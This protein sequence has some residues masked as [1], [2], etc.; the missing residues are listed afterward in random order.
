MDIESLISLFEA[1]VSKDI[2][3]SRFDHSLRVA[4]LAE[5]FAKVHGYPY[6]R[7][8][9]LAGIVHDITKQ[10]KRDFH[11]EIFRKKGFDFSEIPE[12]AFHAFSGALYLEEKFELKDSE[13]LSA[14]RNHTLGGKN[15]NLLD[16]IL[17]TSDFLGSEYALKQSEYHSWVKS[18]EESLYFGVQLKARTVISELISKKESIHLFTIYTY[19]ESSVR[20][21]EGNV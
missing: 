10:K 19:N 8:A 5:R 1:E 9:Y 18:T 21:K 4:A 12:N 2:T 20:L 13:L 11:L 14:V 6:S 17:Y 16:S 7:K 15:L 3:P